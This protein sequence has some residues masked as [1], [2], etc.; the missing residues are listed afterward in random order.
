MG[1]EELN[2]AAEDVGGGETAE[3]PGGGKR[4]GFLPG[5]VITILKYAAIGLGLIIVAATTTIIVVKVMGT[6]KTTESP[7]GS[8]EA[9]AAGREVLVYHE[10][11]QIRGSTADEVQTI[12][13]GGVSI[14][15]KE[16]AKEIADELVRRQK[17]ISNQIMIWL[18][19]KTYQDLRPDKL[20]QIQEQ[21]V[22]VV[23]GVLAQGKVQE[24]LLD[25][26]TVVR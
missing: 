24:V 2:V 23:N 13:A 8:R 18:S 11:G 1:D 16:D 12:F 6:G 21:L 4:T 7:V 17:Q 20:E 25:G 3:A 26:F 14:G 5:A 22:G 9:Y 15:Y 19:K 10:L